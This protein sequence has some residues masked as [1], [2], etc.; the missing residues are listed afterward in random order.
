MGSISYK[1]LS[2]NDLHP[3]AWNPNEMS[4]DTFAK[5]LR[6]I[7]EF[8][9]IDPVTVMKRRDGGFMIIDGEHRWKAAQQLGIASVPAIICD[10]LSETDAKKL[11]TILNGLHGDPNREK[12]GDLLKNLL[13]NEPV[14]SLLGVLPFTETE[15][16]DL[17]GL[18]PFDWAAFEQQMGEPA[19]KTRSAWVERVYRFPA[20]AAETI[21]AA[22]SKVREQ[23]G[24]M[25]DWKALELICADYIA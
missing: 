17:A 11:T 24:E 8:G 12:L 23:E 25:P 15:F 1:S 18:K 16:N 7:R 22:I 6:S 9:F 21:D 19:V 5:E 20:D 4:D 3:N 14:S 13:E 10:G 2:V